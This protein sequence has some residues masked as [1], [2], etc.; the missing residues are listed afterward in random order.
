MSLSF[1]EV[2]RGITIGSGNGDGLEG[3]IIVGS[4]APG[5]AGPNTDADDAL[6]GALYLR[7]G[8]TTEFYQKAVAGTG[9]GVWSRLARESFVLATQANGTSWREPVKLLDATVYAN[10]AAAEAAANV[11]DMIDGVTI[12][13]P[14]R[15]L[16]PNL[17]TGS[18]NVYITSGSTGAWTFTEDTN[19]L[20][21]GDTV[22]V[23]LGTSAGQQWNYNGTI[24]VKIQDQPSA[25]EGFIRSFIG[26]NA[27]G[28]ES[29]VYTSAVIV[30]QGGSLE[31][32][33][34]QLDAQ[35]NLNTIEILQAR[36]EVGP[37]TVTAAAGEV[38]IDSVLVDS[39]AFAKWIVYMEGSVAG[40]AAKK[41]VWEI[42][43]THDGHNTGAGAD[44]TAADYTKVAKLKHGVL[45]DGTLIVDVSGAGASQVMRLRANPT[46]DVVYRVIRE[47][48]LF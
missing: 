19:T 32:A 26:K 31:A 4:V 23:E 42:P 16:F 30:T 8:A 10:I 29:P 1:F 18:D 17:T 38:T 20:S 7:V 35:V 11:A 45:G 33:I 43:A 39:V 25:E 6:A 41:V 48:V 37:T 5:A 40:T 15:I 47:V 13:A 21:A 12:A 24:W 46:E 2:E 34:G 3:R 22:F 27:A 14:Y 28:S 44:A 9:T 36:T